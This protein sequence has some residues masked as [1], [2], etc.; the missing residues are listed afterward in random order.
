[1]TEEIADVNNTCI[2]A[3]KCIKIAD[4]KSYCD[5]METEANVIQGFRDSWVSRVFLHLQLSGRRKM[6]ERLLTRR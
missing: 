5:S 6:I 2:L 4:T 3:A 1:M